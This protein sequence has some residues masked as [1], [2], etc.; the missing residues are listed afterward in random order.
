MK[1]KFYSEPDTY[2]YKKFLV[3]LKKIYKNIVIY[4]FGLSDKSEKKHLFKAYYKNLF[5]HFN[6]SFDL[7]FIKKKIKENYPNKHKSFHI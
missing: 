2:L 4:N 3:P 1:I 6:N 5:L 7:K